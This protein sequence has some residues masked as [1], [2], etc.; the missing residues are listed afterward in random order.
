MTQLQ[1]PGSSFLQ[2]AGKNLLPSLNKGG[3]AKQA[4]GAVSNEPPTAASADS[5]AVAHNVSKKTALVG[6]NMWYAAGT[7]R[8][9]FLKDSSLNNYRIMRGIQQPEAA[10]QAETETAR[11]LRA[12]NAERRSWDAETSVNL[13]SPSDRMKTM[14]TTAAM[15]ATELEEGESHLLLGITTEGMLRFLTHRAVRLLEGGSFQSFLE[16]KAISADV[17]GN[18]SAAVVDTKEARWEEYTRTLRFCD[19]FGSIKK[20]SPWPKTKTE[21]GEEGAAGDSEEKSA[22]TAGGTEVKGKKPGE[23]TNKA[24]AGKTGNNTLGPTSKNKNKNK[25][26]GSKK[27]KKQATEGESERSWLD[28]IAGPLVPDKELGFLNVTGYDVRQFIYVWLQ[29][30]DKKFLTATQESTTHRDLSVCE[31]INCD[32]RFV[33]LRE[34]VG[35]AC[36]FW[37]H[38]QMD[39][40]VDLRSVGS[41]AGNVDSALSGAVPLRHSTV[42]S[43]HFHSTSSTATS[44]LGESGHDSD[45][46]W[47]D[48]K[49]S[50]CS[51][52]E[53]SSDNE[54]NFF[55]LDYFSVRQC[56]ENHDFTATHTV[57]TEGALFGE[58]TTL[59]KLDFSKLLGIVQHIN[60]VVLHT[61]LGFEY[62]R[63]SFCL[64]EAYCTAQAEYRNNGMQWAKTICADEN[65]EDANIF[66]LCVTPPSFAEYVLREEAKG[67]GGN[68][69]QGKA[70][71]A[72]LR[73]LRAEVEAEL[74]FMVR[75]AV[76]EVDLQ[77]SED[78]SNS[79]AKSSHPATR[80][81]Y[82]KLSEFAVDFTRSECQ[83]TEHKQALG[84]FVEQKLGRDYFN[85]TL[86][87]ALLRRKWLD[88]N[89]CELWRIKNEVVPNYPKKVEVKKPKRRGQKPKQ[90]D[91]LQVGKEQEDEEPEP[92]PDNTESI[93]K[94]MLAKRRGSCVCMYCVSKMREMLKYS[95]LH[96]AKGDYLVQ[97]G[98]DRCW[99]RNAD[100]TSDRDAPPSNIALLR[101]QDDVPWYYW[102]LLGMQIQDGVRVMRRKPSH[103]ETGQCRRWND[104]DVSYQ[105]LTSAIMGNFEAVNEKFIWETQE[106]PGIVQQS[107]RW[108]GVR[109]GLD[110]PLVSPDAA[111]YG[112]PAI[113]TMIVD[114]WFARKLEGQVG[115]FE[116]QYP[117]R[118][119]VQE[120]IE[121]S[122]K[123]GERLLGA[124]LQ[125]KKAAKLARCAST[126][127]NEGGMVTKTEAAKVAAN[128]RA[129]GKLFC[130]A[131]QVFEETVSHVAHSVDADF[132][133]RHFDL[134]LLEQFSKMEEAKTEL[135]KAIEREPQGEW[136][137]KRIYIQE[138]LDS[139]S[140][141]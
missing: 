48:G 120:R 45:F 47:V 117:I 10:V 43:M 37:S 25:T 21:N 61:G 82:R 63:R 113:A 40:F 12:Q 52:E 128:R 139:R 91:V 108:L 76:R 71:S 84:D 36:V 104:G 93:D 79:W 7:A 86:H 123:N 44:D 16:Q 14:L 70:A 22:N 105:E 74:L 80:V 53:A 59:V 110:K 116:R 121:V 5:S 11:G 15:A 49:K 51:S 94:R 65:S 100:W 106:Q 58:T 20:G 136:Q 109:W 112:W 8:T 129:V 57:E 24:P 17:D 75:A 132:Q 13:S 97:K 41:S 131:T 87:G 124:Y 62:Y 34:E 68:E 92:E 23:K 126:Q 140:Q 141:Q 137:Y 60:A 115:A 46:T 125:N 118:S 134:L 42:R 73:S 119:F 83:N 33:D 77:N 38:R 78:D 6:R 19:N 99:N 26:K 111:E 30:Q 28:A 35:Q 66:R 88:V 1:K 81:A 39:E 95:V 138:L 4:W 133:R 102:D 107:S 89:Q 114:G 135:D 90:V 72:E 96:D 2:Q 18:N 127:Q 122:F 98:E 55:W 27:K 130:E 67:A 54:P 50:D 56:A 69:G 3:A 85:E 31:V 103:D 64:F 101:L 32:R 29:Q 9:A